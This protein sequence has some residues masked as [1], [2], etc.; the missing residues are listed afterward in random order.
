VSRDEQFGLF[1]TG[2][3]RGHVPHVAGCDTSAAAADSLDGLPVTALRAAVLKAIAAAPQGL[4]CDQVETRLALRH[5]TASARI[6]ELSI[7]GMIED[8][9]R[10]D[11]TRSGRS[12]RVYV[13]TDRQC[14]IKG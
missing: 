10:R 14:P 8:S 12:A 5:Q 13:R 2:P 3:Y 11:R 9:G 7:M 4:T 1:P 6:R